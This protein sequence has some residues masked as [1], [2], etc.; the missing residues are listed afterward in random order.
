[1]FRIYILIVIYIF[2]PALIIYLTEKNSI[3]NRIGTV[4]IAYLL[5][6]I[7][8]HIGLIPLPSDFFYE[9][10]DTNKKLTL[11]QLGHLLS[12]D[13]IAPKDIIFYKIRSFQN[14]LLTITIPLALPLLLFSVNIKDWFR[15]AG[16]TIISMILA[17]I[18]VIV[19]V[20]TGFFIFR[21]QLPDLW[22]VSGMLIGLYTGG[23]PNLAAL[24]MMLDVNPETYIL[25]HTYDM[26][27]SL[28]YLFFI[29]TVGKGI[30]RQFLNPYPRK[31]GYYEGINQPVNGTYHGIL[32][33]E[34]IIPLSFALLITV[35]IFAV[36]G[37][38]S[39][40]VKENHVMIV[41]ILAITTLSILVSAIPKINKID[42]TFELGMYFILIFSMVVASMADVKQLAHV[43][44]SL[45]YYITYAVFLSFFMH[46]LLSKLF[47][48]DADTVMVTSAALI[49]SPPFVPVVA[50]A[51]NNRE[52]IVSGLT[53][54]I[55]GY[56]IGNYLGIIL[57]Y[58]LQGF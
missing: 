40:L 48:V 2:T 46:V 16:K 9:L 51:L 14:L 1:M 47:K 42:K 36:A 17:T 29:I 45:F 52:V 56:A 8:G 13:L 49:C 44:S 50:G 32:S 38:L 5:G 37:G 6:L 25:T 43:S 33:R 35:L 4:I 23:T 24:K 7:L 54:G 28:V 55:I 39:L 57:A 12:Q 30:F 31:D 34:K 19:I 3:A 11:S 53:V 41:V 27:I 15:M 22:K 26:V 10:Y 20:G 18:A 58:F 21:N